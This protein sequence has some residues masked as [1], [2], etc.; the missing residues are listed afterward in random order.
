MSGKNLTIAIVG[1]TGALGSGL[2]LRWA[3]AGHTVIIGSRD[4]DRAAQSA[5]E[6]SEKVGVQI[7]G[8]ENTEAAAAGELVVLTVPYSNHQATVELIQP[9]VDGKIFIDVTVPLMP[10]K[11]RTVQLPEPGSVVKGTQNFLG[12]D[13][14]VVSAFQ[15]VAAAHLVDLDHKID[16]DVLV[17]GNDS[18]A[19]EAVIELAEDAG[20]RGW[21]AGRIDNSAVAE[22]LT[23]VLIFM[24]G[25]Y[26][27]DGAGIRIMGEPGSTQKA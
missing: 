2:A 4:G 8:M 27:F 19:R 17:C 22:A 20:M 6:L 5:K 26:K 15:N 12:E 9:H 24:N 13:V 14:R 18:K 7:S 10:P 3:K 21:H 16:C 23:S 1:G 25:H 11:V